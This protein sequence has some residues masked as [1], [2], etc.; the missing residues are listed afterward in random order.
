MSL[1]LDCHG[2][3]QRNSEVSRVII[4]NLTVGT[5]KLGLLGKSSYTYNLLPPLTAHFLSET[6]YS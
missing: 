4:Y 6:H 1:Y 3:E 5:I 2:I